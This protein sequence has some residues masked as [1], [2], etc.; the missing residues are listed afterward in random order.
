MR[1]GEIGLPAG[2]EARLDKERVWQHACSC[3][4]GWVIYCAVHGLFAR[5][6][7]IDERMLA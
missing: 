4:C 2:M 1:H 5:V 6:C 7:T 3:D